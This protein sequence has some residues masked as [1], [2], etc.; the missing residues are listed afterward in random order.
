MAEDSKKVSIIIPTY[1]R[2][3][4]LAKTIPS[5][6]QKN[7]GE[8]IVIDDGSTDRT[9][10][11]LRKIKED[12]PELVI[13][14]N[15]KNRKQTYSKN[16][17]IKT[18]QYPY[19]YFGDDDSFITEGTI[20]TLLAYAEKIPNSLISARPLYTGSESQIRYLDQF[21]RYT[22]KHCADDGY[23]FF[24]FNTMSSDTSAYY[25]KLTKVE[26][27]P[28]CFLIS[29]ENVRKIRFDNNFKLANA[30]REESDYVMQAR[31]A[32]MECYF[33]PHAYQINYPR[34]V[35]DKKTGKREKM[36]DCWGRFQNTKYFLDK[37]Y[38][39]MRRNGMV[40]SRKSRILLR[41]LCSEIKQIG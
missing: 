4:I 28:A 37:H 35:S 40:C 2:A 30:F 31:E 13:L 12:I 8:I 15:R 34:E 29:S 5:Y 11:V 14:R 36:A 6:L 22:E 27:I 26:L 17:G 39:F 33:A 9:Q 24:D 1:N 7:V 41:Y 20:G 38:D 3:H 25:T 10:K 19:I 23:C 21:I 32:G 16:K 18:A